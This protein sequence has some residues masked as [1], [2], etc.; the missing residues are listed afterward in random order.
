MREGS[1]FFHSALLQEVEHAT[2]GSVT[3][4][5]TDRPLCQ[6]LKTW[7]LKQREHLDSTAFLIFIQFPAP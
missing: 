2:E 7:F 5:V 4:G 1:H 6:T 3:K